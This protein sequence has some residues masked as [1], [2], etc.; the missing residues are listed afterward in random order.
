MDRKEFLKQLGV[1]A[2]MACAGCSMLSCGSNDPEPKV[3]FTLD[4]KTTTSLSTVGGF[5]LKN[6]IIIV[7]FDT[8]QYVAFNKAC[9]HQGTTVAYKSTD[10]KFVCPNHGSEFDISG[11]LT[12]GPSLSGLRRYN[13]ELNSTEKTLRIFSS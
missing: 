6:G 9:P 1:G 2:V 8:D 13:T 7:Q 3:N 12:K 4:L 11:N 10:K 5:I